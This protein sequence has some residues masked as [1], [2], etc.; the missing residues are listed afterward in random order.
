MV[1]R[2][3][4]NKEFMLFI[5]AVLL[6]LSPIILAI[7]LLEVLADHIGE[8]WPM[9]K[10]AAWQSAK[11]GREFRGGDGKS[12]LT[13]KVSRVRLLKP[14][15]L[16]IGASRTNS[17]RAEHFAPISFFNA[18]LTSWTF[19]HY[20]RFLEM[21]TDRTY[22]PKILIVSV[23]YWMFANNFDEMWKPRFYDKPTPHIADLKFVANELISAP[24]RLIKR[25]PHAANYKGMYAF[26]SGDGFK[27]DGSLARGHA[28]SPDINRLAQ[29]GTAVGVPPLM[30]GPSISKRQK[31]KFE[32]FM[33]AA[34][35]RNITVI[36]IQAPY[37]RR[38][39]D[40]L[41]KSSKAGIWREFRSAANRRYL[42]STGLIFFDFAYMKEFIDKPQHFVDSIHPDEGILKNI[43]DLVKSDPRVLGVFNGSTK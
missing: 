23:D 35:A 17:F 14:K 8:S 11:P 36:G 24:M 9:S 20:R 16:V 3:W 27:A 39:F 26:L 30:L 41:E 13:Y 37:H 21:A 29:D 33:A 2:N 12:Y 43:I 38:I 4:V 22:A 25:L 7:V 19:D 18:G 31:E 15:V 34:K 28:L 5:R 6:S 42:E 40:V 10:V 1:V 32:R